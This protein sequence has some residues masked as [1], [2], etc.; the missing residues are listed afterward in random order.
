MR[1]ARF[2]VLL[3]LLLSLFFGCS[4]SREKTASV[5]FLD[6]G[7]G[8]AT[9]LQTP[10]GNV[11]VDCGPE[12]AQET[13]CR[14]LKARGIRSLQFLVLTHPDEDHIGGADVILEQFSVDKILYNGAAEENESFLRLQTGAE[15]KKIPMVALD[16]DD[17]AVLGDLKLTILHP[18][19]REDPGEGN[20]SSLVFRVQYGAAAILFT[21]DADEDVEEALLKTC[22]AESLAATVL[23]VGHHGSDTSSTAE[24]LAAVHPNYA[25]ISCGAGNRY[26]HPDGRVLERLDAVGAKV[27]R[28]DLD[29]DI[30]FYWDGETLQRQE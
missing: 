18:Q 20:E 19:D 26:G 7:Q 28:T 17:E 4:A 6:V 5:V 13:L 2:G 12:S 9:L 24:F 30:V 25:V 15:Q 16:R 3:L 21:G 11:L 23:Q 10:K 8:N 1:V 27:L 14:K 29:G 22:G